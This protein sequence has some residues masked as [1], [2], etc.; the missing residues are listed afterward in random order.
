MKKVNIKKIILYILLL[1]VL[2][3]VALYFFR[4]ARIHQQD[5]R[6]ITATS[7]IDANMPIG[8]VVNRFGISEAVILSE[9][10]LPNVRWNRRY[11]IADAC[12]K[13]KLDCQAVVDSLNKKIAR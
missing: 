2:F 3:L 13:N 12:K 1:L 4:Q 11:T 8:F 6:N 10:Q 9:L 7:V 5:Y